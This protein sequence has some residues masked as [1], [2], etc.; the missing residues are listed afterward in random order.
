MPPPKPVKISRRKPRIVGVIAN[1][2]ELR[3]AT[4][5]SAP[6][7]LFELRLDALVNERQL[8]KKARNLPAPLIIT[9]RHPAEGGEHNLHVTKRRDLLLRFLPLAQYV[10]IELRS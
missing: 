6:P 4:R 9:A 1:A 10:D 2:S 5:M 7:D 8:E 3:R